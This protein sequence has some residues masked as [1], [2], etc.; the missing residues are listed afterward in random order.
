M[1]VYD[2]YN[3]MLLQP[4]RKWLAVMPVDFV[5]TTAWL[6]YDQFHVDCQLI[7]V[8][9]LSW[10][11]VRPAARRIPS[12]R[13]LGTRESP[14]NLVWKPF[15]AGQAHSFS[16]QYYIRYE[17]HRWVQANQMIQIIFSYNF[18]FFLFQFFFL[19]RKVFCLSKKYPLIS[20]R[21]YS[22]DIRIVTE[23]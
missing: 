13:S 5:Q 20:Q 9:F 19:G 4:L 11:V 12:K 17:P 6:V 21:S 16:S 3:R 18:V 14:Q 8:S 2:V 22:V 10:N 15:L 23:L 7:V 1:D